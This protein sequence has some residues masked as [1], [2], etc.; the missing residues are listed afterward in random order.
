MYLTPRFTTPLLTAAC[1][2]LSAVPAPASET[3]HFNC[4]GN[5][6]SISVTLEPETGTATVV[7]PRGTEQL[8]AESDGV[9]RDATQELQFYAEETPPT[10]WMGSEQ[11][12]CNPV[13]AGA[14]QTH[15]SGAV[16]GNESMINAAGRS[17]GGRL[18]NGPGTNFGVTGSLAE[19]TP[20]TI[21]TN[22]GVQFDGYDWFEIR[23]GN[24][25]SAYQWGGIMCSEARQI[26][27]IYEQCRP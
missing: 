21:V 18:R 3:A 10:L 14:T 11:I 15:A 24:G 26:A 7:S 16:G 4:G 2:M 6:L 9:W 19:G 5:G 25:V 22:T 12:S 8:R 1:F 23:T 20:V 27:G 17:L 13:L